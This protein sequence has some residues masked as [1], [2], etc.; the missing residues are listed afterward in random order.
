L[1]QIVPES[2]F[3]V[4]EITGGVQEKFL[5]SDQILGR[6]FMN[7][8]VI[9]AN[10]SKWLPCAEMGGTMSKSPRRFTARNCLAE[11]FCSGEV[12]ERLKADFRR[13]IQ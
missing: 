10:V 2:Q 12:I 5:K 3:L 6:Y 8:T 11:T 9:W 7:V 13:L 1:G 4:K